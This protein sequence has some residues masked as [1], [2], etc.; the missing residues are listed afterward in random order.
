MDEVLKEIQNKCGFVGSIILGGPEPKFG[1][2]LMIVT[3]VIFPLLVSR[4]L[5]IA[6]RAHSNTAD[7]GLNFKQAH[8]GWST[9]VEAQFLSYLHKAFRASASPLI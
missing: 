9:Q 5:L 3:C 8:S 1:G 2:K 4:Q 6:S 7:V